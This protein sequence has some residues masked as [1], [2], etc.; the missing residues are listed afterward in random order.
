MTTIPRR[1]RTSDV[2]RPYGPS[3]ATRVPRCIDA[4][5]SPSSPRVPMVMRSVLAVGAADSEIG[6]ARVQPGPVW[7]RQTK[8]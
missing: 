8:N 5:R 3:I 7:K 4:I 2:S 1:V 6:C